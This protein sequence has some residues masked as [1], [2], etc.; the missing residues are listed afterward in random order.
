LH[1]LFR[2]AAS[3]SVNQAVPRPFESRKPSH[4]RDWVGP[5]TLSRMVTFPDGSASR[6]CVL[7]RK[8][9][10]SAIAWITPG[11]PLEGGRHVAPGSATP[12]RQPRVRLFIW[13][14]AHR[15]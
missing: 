6:I 1:H 9:P 12:I 10:G 11:L 14:A 3:A 7:R 15:P 5:V 4:P 13:L 2:K 8:R